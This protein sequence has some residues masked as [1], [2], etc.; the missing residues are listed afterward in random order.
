M[1]LLQL[2]T[3]LST[4]VTSTVAHGHVSGIV[5]DGTYYQGYDPSFQYQSTPPAVVGWSCPDCLDNGFVAP[6]AYGTS[7]ITC[8]KDATPGQAHATVAAGGTVELQWTTWPSSHHGPVLSYLAKC[9]GKCESVD[10]DDLSFF[11]I[12][13]AGLIDDTTVPG[14]WAT[15]ELIANNNSWTL[16]IP[17]GIT[18]GNY[19]L[20]HEIIA[21]HSAG[22]EDGAQNYPAC[23]NLAIT[24]SGTDAPAGVAGTR[25]YKEDDAGIL[26]NIYQTL[27]SYALPGPTLYSGAESISQTAAASSLTSSAVATPS[28]AGTPSVSTSATAAAAEAT[29]SASSSI[30]TATT[31]TLV[32][33]SAAAATP[34]PTPTSTSAPSSLS[35]SSPPSTSLPSIPIPTG[36]PAFTGIGSFTALPSGL[37]TS[38]LPTA[39]PT[40]TDNSSGELP[41]TPL[42]AGMTLKEFLKWFNYIMRTYFRKGPEQGERKHPRDIAY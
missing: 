12:D 7:N 36:L 21:L 18:T 31:S 23:I 33:S 20:R 3:L 17:S 11:K 13:E 15:D 22:T 38:V 32:L 25:L 9:S 29:T 24:G 26:V 37:L 1:S 19:V 4:L 41:S 6:D 28:T 35:P 10:K 2:A 14:Y 34:T 16:K 30:S 27:A 42:P 39:V 5:A 40:G 8:H